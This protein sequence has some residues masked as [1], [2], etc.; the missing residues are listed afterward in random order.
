MWPPSPVDEARRVAGFLLFTTAAL[1]ALPVVYVMV[2][3]D[4]NGL[5]TMLVG[6]ASMGLSWAGGCVLQWR[7]VTSAAIISAIVVLAPAMFLLDG[8]AAT[9][10]WFTGFVVAMTGLTATALVVTFAP[11]R[12]FA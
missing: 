11:A 3:R 4:I 12:F 1:A 6:V 10:G 8:V 2:A 9:M 7:R 5:L